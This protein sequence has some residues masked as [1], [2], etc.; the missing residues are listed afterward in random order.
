MSGSV[1]AIAAYDGTGTQSYGTTDKMSQGVK[2]VFWCEND[3][4]KYYVNGSSVS[5]VQC[6]KDEI[7]NPSE[8]VVF[9]F[10]NDSDAVN[11]LTLCIERDA[12]ADGGTDTPIYT[13]LYSIDRVE[14]VLGNQ[15][16]CTINTTQL[17]KEFFDSNSYDIF[18][19]TVAKTG[20]AHPSQVAGEIVAQRVHLNIFSMLCKNGVDS[21]YLM[22]LA[23]NQSLQLKV[24]PQNFSADD[25]NSYIGSANADAQFSSFA[26]AK[27]TYRLFA[28][29][30]TMTNAERDFLRN[31]DVPKRTNMTQYAELR[32][33][34]SSGTIPAG[35]QITV[36]CDHFNLY[37]SNVYIVG[38]C[39]NGLADLGGFDVELYL[40]SSSY[41]GILPYHIV[42]YRPNLA[43]QGANLNAFLYYKIPIADCANVAT[44]DQN[45]VPFGKF[46]SI[47]VVLTAKKDI[48]VADYTDFFNTLTVVAEG[49]CTA[50]YQGGA[51]V[52][53]NY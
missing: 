26:D 40:N 44:T 53:N 29:R 34:P 52:F 5:E 18:Q 36:D 47:R 38:M 24:Y 2:S 14:V 51:V 43:F 15:V 42:S 8:L 21:S 33:K 9:T 48:T 13:L 12:A 45:Y 31:Q 49:K 17:V 46:D 4:D 10:D 6:N 19:D 50:L 30:Y 27:F 28:N 1:A 37:T 16:I 11:N 23:N 22:G 39:H 35:G 20:G 41:S 7:S 3:K 32:V 25:M